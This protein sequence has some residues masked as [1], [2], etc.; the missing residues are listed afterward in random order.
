MGKGIALEA[1]TRFPGFDIQ[2]GNWLAE[3]GNVI[4]IDHD[5]RLFTFPVKATY[6]KPAQISLI[7]Q[8]CEQFIDLY[9]HFL[10]SDY[11]FYLARPG[12]GAGRLLWANVKPVML[13][14]FDKIDNMFICSKTEVVNKHREIYDIDITRNSLFGNPF[15]VEQYGREKC[16]KYFRSYFEDRINK[17]ADF[18]RHVLELAGQRLGCVC[19]PHL[20]CHGDIIQEWLYDQRSN[21]SSASTIK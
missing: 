9:Q 20:D 7:R 14:Y 17:D 6:D 16:L 8:S 1:N 15:S 4:M 12:C 18:R 13:E 19:K 3:R 11:G 2:V 21:S 10:F 5:K